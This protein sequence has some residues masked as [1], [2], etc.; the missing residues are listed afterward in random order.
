MSIKP[1]QPHE[2]KTCR[3]CSRAMPWGAF[4]IDPRYGTPRSWCRQCE[5]D[6][7]SAY[8]YARKRTRPTTAER[9]W[10]KVDKR[11]GPLLAPE[12]GRCWIWTGATKPN[13]YGSFR[14]ADSRRT[15]SAP[16]VAFRLEHG[17]DATPQCLHRCDGGSIG[18]V[19]PEHLYAGTHADNM[20]DKVERGRFTV[21]LGSSH[22]NA[23]LEEWE[24]AAIKCQA[25]ERGS[26]VRLARLFGISKAVV[27]KIRLG[28]AWGHLC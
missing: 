14:S 1:I 21:H 7:R 3:R 8:Y 25:V 4:R 27:S 6:E 22:H 18:C 26:G 2:P 24:A 17:H 23:K 16:R 15:E 11:N 20:R 5:R 9:F 10:A 12:L 28:Q 13:G 19:R